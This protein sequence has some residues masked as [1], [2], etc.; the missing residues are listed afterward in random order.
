MTFSSAVV[1]VV[2]RLGAGF[3]GPYGNTWIDT[4][5]LNR[6]ASQSLVC[7]TVLADAPDLATAYRSYWTGRHALEPTPERT[8]IEEL[9]RQGIRTLL[10][11]DEPLV[12]EH[13]LAAAFAEIVRVETQ[14]AAQC[15]ADPAETGL[16]RLTAAA[17]EAIDAQR[18]AALVW[19]HARGMQGA[20]D[21][22]L[23]YRMQFRDEEDPVPGEWTEPP[24][25][26]IDEAF[27]PDELLKLTHA[28]AGQVALF[29]QCLGHLMEVL[30]GR[31]E[32][33][34]LAAV[35]SPRGYPLGEHGRVG[36]CDKALYVELVHVPLMV[37]FAGGLGRLRRSQQVLQP[38]ELGRCLGW[39]FGGGPSG[40][41]RIARLEEAGEAE[42]AVAAAPTQRAIRT[43][44]WFLRQSLADGQTKV[45]LF[46]KPD[47][48]WEVNEVSSRCEA[49]VELLAAK[50]REFEELAAQG[51]LAELSPLSPL[52]RDTWR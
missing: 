17:A 2:D 7:E 46:A 1:F 37:R 29:D 27:D 13:P 16:A 6:L 41:V 19:V 36:P 24:Q 39:H 50:L 43:P 12:A 51:R 35:T 48:R 20:W 15:A 22:P 42:V 5:H 10:V 18:Q 14:D 33:Q 25:L 28:Y 34:W 31:S 40:L 44:A 21:A 52:L 26:R 49:E 23:D 47:D 38:A 3:V 8:L 4:P 30:S 11:T 32:G 45:E 9:D